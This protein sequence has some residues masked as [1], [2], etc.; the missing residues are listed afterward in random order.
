MGEGSIFTVRLPARVKRP[1]KEATI[2]PTTAAA[3][4]LTTAHAA[5]EDPS[6]PSKGTVLVIDDD[7]NAC[8]LMVRSL[9]KEG[10]RVLTATEGVDGLRLAREFHPHVITLDVLMPGM[11]GWSVL[12]ELKADPKLSGIPVIMITM[13]DDRSTGYALGASDYLTKPIDRERLAASVRRYRQGTQGVLVVEDDDDTREMMVRT[14]GNDGWTVRAAA[15]G[16]LALDRVRESVPELILLDLMMPEMDG[17]EFIAHLRENEA[18]R[19]IPVVVLTA[20]DITPEDHLRLQGNVRK[21]FRKA[22]F[23]RDELIEEIRA[24][25]EPRGSGPLES[26]A[27]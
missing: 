5:P 3:L 26:Q 4:G 13:A 16:R 22:S 1:V 10:F 12:R 23:S 15:N 27:S 24:A 25:M 7:P 21:V 2:V 20:K 18:W 9:S 17:F 8:E 19:S 6:A 14:L 11:D